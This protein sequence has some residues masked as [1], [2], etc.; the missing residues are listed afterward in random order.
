MNEH[1]TTD[2]TDPIVV[3]LAWLITWGIGRAL[4][5]ASPRVRAGMPLLA[6]L[7]ALGLRVAFDAAQGHPLTV[8]TLLR[9]LAAGGVAVAGHSQFREAVK[10]LDPAGYQKRHKPRKGSPGDHP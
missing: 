4:K 9:A 2:T 7:A 5:N 1:L 10:L 8:D 6:L 3:I